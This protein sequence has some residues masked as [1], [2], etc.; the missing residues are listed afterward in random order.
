M[1]RKKQGCKSEDVENNIIN[2]VQVYPSNMSATLN[3]QT[4]VYI[5]FKEEVNNIDLYTVRM[6]I[7]KKIVPCR[8]EKSGAVYEP[9]NDFFSGMHI[10]NVSFYTKE[11][12]MIN[13]DWSFNVLDKEDRY[14][15]YFGVPHCH[16]SYSSGEGLPQNAFQYAKKKKLNY[17]IITDHVR[18]LRGKGKLGKDGK[19]VINDFDKWDAAKYEGN[20]SIK[21]K[22]KFLGLVGFELSTSFFGHVNIYYSK[23]YID[24]KIKNSYELYEWLKKQGN[25]V[26]CINHPT[27][28]IKS[29]EYSSKLDEFINLIEVGNGAPPFKYTRY[30]D[31]YYTLL[32]KGW[33]L[34][35]VNGQDNHK[36]NWGN[37]DN[38]TVVIAE[39]ISEKSFKDAFINRRVYS[40]ES[41]YLRLMVKANDCW[42]GSVLPLEKE[43]DILFKIA[44]EDKKNPIKRIELISN[45]GKVIKTK[46]CKNEK[47]VRWTFPLLNK[48]QYTWFVVKII[49]KNDK[50]GMSSPIFTR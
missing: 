41:R 40:T 6:Y 16:T 42:M 1:R 9:R 25:V 22:K 10:A 45:G 23:N 37:E 39:D 49:H 7:D 46:E 31:I 17:L 8:V 13:I 20:K 48:N 21:K 18:K 19:K 29:L 47:K 12:K 43:D 3:K 28:K 14:R 32:D 36:Q 34:G 2:R 30:E 44:A 35:A 50:W 5:S 24:R 26:V 4:K 11:G 33:H 27:N 38:L 15:F